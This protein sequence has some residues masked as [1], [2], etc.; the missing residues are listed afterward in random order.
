MTTAARRLA[1]VNVAA[2]IRRWVEEKL[3]WYDPVAVRERTEASAKLVARAD[4]AVF[5]AELREA[6]RAMDE[7]LP[8]K[9]RR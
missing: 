2:R 3:P 7:R 6:Y 5:T 4:R 1:D 9:P 8:G